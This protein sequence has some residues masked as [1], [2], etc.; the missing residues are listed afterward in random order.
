VGLSDAASA[1]PNEFS[2][3]MKQRVAR[4]Y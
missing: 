2:G 1:Y 3:G 4:R